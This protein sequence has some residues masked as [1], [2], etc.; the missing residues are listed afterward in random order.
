MKTKRF[1]SRLVRSIW[2]CKTAV[3]TLFWK[4]GPPR[5]VFFRDHVAL[6]FSRKRAAASQGEKLSAHA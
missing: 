4:E 3:R 6:N 2:F 1:T 5:V